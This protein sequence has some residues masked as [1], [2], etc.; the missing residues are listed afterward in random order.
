MTTE[1]A[2]WIVSWAQLRQK[3]EKCSE[4]LLSSLRMAEAKT[5]QETKREVIIYF[6]NVIKFKLVFR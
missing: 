1:R 6:I 3:I 5:E 4:D 2:E